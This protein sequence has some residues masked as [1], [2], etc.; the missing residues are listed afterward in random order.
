MKTS[1]ANNTTSWKMGSKRTHA[2]S[3]GVGFF[4]LLGILF[5]GLKLGGVIDWGW[6]YVLMPLW[7]GPAIVLSILSFI[8]IGL[9]FLTV[10]KKAKRGM[11]R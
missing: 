11:R 3:G 7:I 2:P 4:G 1:G 5:I 8:G 10:L 9:L 6:F